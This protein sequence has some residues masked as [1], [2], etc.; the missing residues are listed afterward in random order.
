MRIEDRLQGHAI[1]REQPSGDCL[2]GAAGEDHRQAGAGAPG[3]V[4]PAARSLK[5]GRVRT[6]KGLQ[7]DRCLA[8][9]FRPVIRDPRRRHPH[10]GQQQEAVVGDDPADVGH[11]G[12][13]GPANGA[14]TGTE[15][16]ARRDKADATKD[17]VRRGMNPVADLT[18]RNAGPSFRV[19]HGHHQIPTTPIIPRINP[20][21]R[22]ITQ[23]RQPTVH[24]EI[25]NDRNLRPRATPIHR[26]RN[27]KTHI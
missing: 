16:D 23:I 22:P 18:A 4:S 1:I 24:A 26:L 15:R 17:A 13:G 2:S 19:M 25:R 5:A 20:V 12:I 11:A 21:Q 9:S 3:T 27:R 14:I 6:H 7:Q 8:I 10:P